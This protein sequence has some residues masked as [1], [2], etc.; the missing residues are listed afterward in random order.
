M[1]MTT[2][3]FTL[4]LATLLGAENLAAGKPCR[5]E[6]APNYEHCTDPGDS[7]QLT[8]GKRV[9]GHFWTQK[10]T[11]GWSGCSP[12]IITID[13]GA[14]RPISGLSY[15]TAAGVAGVEL[16][17]AV[18]VL[19]SDDRK[20]WH[21]AGDLVASS[22]RKSPAA[23]AS[24]YAEHVLRAD[25]L[26]TRSRFVTLLVEANGPFVFVDEVEVFRGP[27]SLLS[28]PLPGQPWSDVGT[29][30]EAKVPGQSL[31]SLSTRCRRPG[32]SWLLPD[33]GDSI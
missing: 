5:L 20:V 2:T 29:Y 15:H 32:S 6:P 27:G 10:R 23:A 18:V 17:A 7:T 31:S 16:P 24:G 25:E 4:A 8:D 26:A 33:P 1:L 9:R 28:R 12:V 14:V 22:S 11:V 19:V 13:L 21:E 30:H 3:W